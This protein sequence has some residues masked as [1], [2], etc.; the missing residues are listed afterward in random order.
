MRKKSLHTSNL[1]ETDIEVKFERMVCSQTFQMEIE[2]Y[3]AYFPSIDDI[4]MSPDYIDFDKKLIIISTVRSSYHKVHTKYS[5]GES[6]FEATVEEIIREYESS[7]RF[8]K[9]K[10]R[11]YVKILVAWTI[12]GCEI[13]NEDKREDKLR[14]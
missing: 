2:S 10:L 4:M 1:K 11:L 5:N 7:M 3:S 9:A 14:A 6:I 12:L 8:S 13:F